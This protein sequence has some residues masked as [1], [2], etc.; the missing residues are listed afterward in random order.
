ME[1]AEVE[2]AVHAPGLRLVLT[3]GVPGPWGETAKSL[4]DYKGL[5]YLPVRQEAG[6]E[7]TALMSWTGQSSAP[8]AVFDDLPPVCHWLDLLHLAERLA[9]SPALLPAD[10]AQRVE[11]LGL[12]AL[13]AG[14][15][16]FGWQRRLQL[17]APAMAL[18][19]PPISI[20]RMA[21]KYGW[22]EQAA[23][24]AG[25]RMQGIAALL[26]QRLA[27]QEATGKHWFVGDGVTAADFYWAN[28]LGMVHPLPADVNPMPDYLRGMY[29]SGAQDSARWLT[30]R[31]LDHRER[32]YREHIRLPLEF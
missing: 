18:A 24:Q 9:P 2:Q 1:Y 11:V 27:A 15:D 23:A 22:S 14:V 8:V 30:P 16:G 28:F 20:Q 5:K 7:N 17:L 26:D 21:G 12:S 6:G 3:A 10:P 25:E 32:M 19:E 31:L 13:I 29:S 4:F